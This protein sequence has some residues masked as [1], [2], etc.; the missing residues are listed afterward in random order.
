MSIDM[1]QV[2][3]ALAENENPEEAFAESLQEKTAEELEAASTE[4]QETETP[5]TQE[6]S[7]E[8][9]VEAVPTDEEIA[10]VAEADA[11]G[12][13]MANAFKDQMD[14]LGVA[15]M[16]DYPAD[17]GAIP[18][19]PALEVGRGEPAQPHADKSG[20]VNAIINSLVAANKVGAG[21]IANP[22]GVSPQGKVDPQDGNMPLAADAA[23]AQER[24]AVPGM[25]YEKGAEAAPEEGATLIVNTLFNKYVLGGE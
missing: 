15:P 7:T 25:D 17:P 16:A 18:N 9:T 3:K 8:E 24:A 12:R 10:K 11:Q 22:A 20:K 6:A 23:K 2:L 21:E 5:E 14:K 4:K 19:N 1:D 13:V